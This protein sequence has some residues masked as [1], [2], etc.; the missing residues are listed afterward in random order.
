MYENPGSGSP[1]Q[2]TGTY[3]VSDIA[4]DYDIQLRESVEIFSL[5]NYTYLEAPSAY[6]LFWYNTTPNPYTHRG[7]K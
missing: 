1:R 2:D 7:G 3:L 4:N 5:I 6:K